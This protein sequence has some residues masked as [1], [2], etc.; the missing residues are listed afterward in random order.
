MD[1]QRWA[2]ILGDGLLFQGPC[3][4]THL[5]MHPDANQDYSDFYDG[6]DATAGKLFGRL[7][8]ATRTTQHINLW[9]GI[10]FDVGIYVDAYDSAVRTTVAFIP[11]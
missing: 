1:N 9:P 6:R 3:L 8:C 7:S 11:L 2:T 10:P 4:V 5:I